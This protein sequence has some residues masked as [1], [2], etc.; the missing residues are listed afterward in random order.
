MAST[1]HT[2]GST[3]DT[4][5]KRTLLN[6]IA[7][8]RAIEPEEI[9]DLLAACGRLDIEKG[10]VLLSPMN[11]NQCVY[12]VLS[13]ELAVHIGSL[14]SKRIATLTP[15]S[16]TGEMSIIDDKDPS[17]YVIATE[18]SHLMVISY[19]LMWDMVERSHAFAKNLSFL[20]PIAGCSFTSVEIAALL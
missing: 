11:E 3:S 5:F 6:S 10:Q 15:G 19:R 9:A 7:L 18:D 13:G 2:T 14:Q 1:A 17:A 16:C 12:I 4:D 20:P 8:F